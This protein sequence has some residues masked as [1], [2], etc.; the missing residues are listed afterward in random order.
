[1][2]DFSVSV[3]I[4]AS[5]DRVWAVLSDAERW[6][7]W[8]PTVTCIEHMDPGSLAVGNRLR[9][10]QPKF[11]PAVW[12]LTELE[13]RKGFTWVT[14]GPG[15]LV[16]ARHWINATDHGSRATLSLQ[17]SGLFGPL[18][19]YLTRDLNNRYLMLEARGLK[20][21]SESA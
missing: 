9:I 20:A 2:K 21:R 1:M 16:S 4:Q 11:P 3:E 14:H 5:P 8:T 12:Q 15:V 19:S 7:E 18:V 10:Y 6:P 13:E 17:F